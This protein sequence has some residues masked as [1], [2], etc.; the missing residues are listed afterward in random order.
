MLIS[1]LIYH[2]YIHRF[3]IPSWEL[4]YPRFFSFS[5]GGICWFPW[6]YFYMLLFV[7]VS[8]F[9]LRSCC[10]HP[11]YSW[12][13]FHLLW[14]DMVKPF[15]RLKLGDLWK[16]IFFGGPFF[17]GAIISNI[18]I[19]IFIHVLYVYLFFSRWFFECLPKNEGLTQ[20]YCF[21]IYTYTSFIMKDD[22]EWR[23]AT[24]QSITHRI[25]V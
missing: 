25:H 13:R 22:S 11:D 6:G 3:D 12:L 17:L 15:T 2:I 10:I 9:F 7:F 20:S 5:Q 19:Y 8:F 18:Y 21:L 23:F 24:I 16:A 1:Y 4:T 14:S